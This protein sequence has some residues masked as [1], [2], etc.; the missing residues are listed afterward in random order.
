M[1]NGQVDQNLLTAPPSDKEVYTKID[2]RPSKYF[3]LWLVSLHIEIK[4][5][6]K[7]L[8]DLYDQVNP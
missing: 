1:A 2:G 8:K 7:I 6:S 3:Y 4:A 5:I